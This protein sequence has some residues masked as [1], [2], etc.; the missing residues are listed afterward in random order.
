MGKKFLTT[1]IPILTLTSLMGSMLN[2]SP[3]T[4]SAK[5][6]ERTYWTFAEILKLE[7]ETDAA[8]HAS[9]GESSQCERDYAEQLYWEH[10]EDDQRYALVNNLKNIK[11]QVTSVNPNE[12]T[13]SIYYN[14]KD[15][16]AIE[17][18]GEDTYT[19][20]RGLYII[21][22]DD[23]S[24][25]TKSEFFSTIDDKTGLQYVVDMDNG[26]P[27]SEGMHAVF[28]HTTSDGDTSS[29]LKSGEESVL[30]VAG[31]NLISD[32][33]YRLY[34]SVYTDGDYNL[35]ASTYYG[36]MASDYGP[37]MEY[38]LV[39]DKEGLYPYWR[40]QLVGDDFEKE[41][42]EEPEPTSP[43]QPI[44]PEPVTPENPDQ[45]DPT[46]S[47]TT[48]STNSESTSSENNNSTDSA[49]DASSTIN[50]IAT[51]AAENISR[52][53]TSERAIS[54]SAI[55]VP[56]IA[57]NTVENTAENREKV[58]NQSTVGDIPSGDY[59]EVPLAASK[60]EEP[61]FPWWL[62]VFIFSGIF[63]VLWWFIPVRRRKD[64][65]ED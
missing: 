51:Q 40:P 26:D 17:F 22:A 25:T 35:A 3:P 5:E 15:F 9:C 19:H 14:D 39:Y 65:E 46:D 48:N 24:L 62:I 4:A 34:H 18:T 54:T 63:L 27:M 33:N 37:G 6:S 2:F 45:V 11:F 49:S 58:E 7:K 32:P 29:W 30:N 10:Y 52:I 12:E 44:N 47:E 31:S 60:K 57:Q 16:S 61:G 41:E 53:I 43:E 56:E 59:V 28:A 8:A 21:W 50:T 64:D 42:P 55:G 38:R 20:L 1:T 23:L 36:R 13:I